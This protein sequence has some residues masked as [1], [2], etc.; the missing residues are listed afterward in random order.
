MG[1]I[2]PP[3]KRGRQMPPYSEAL[4]T[5]VRALVDRL[6]GSS[7][8]AK[9]RIESMTQL[10]EAIKLI[11]ELHGEEVKAPS[12]IAS[13][14]APP[15]ADDIDVAAEAPPPS[16]PPVDDSAIGADT[17]GNIVLDLLADI[18]D[19]LAQLVGADEEGAMPGEP[20]E[21]GE[22]PPVPDEGEEGEDGPVAAIPEPPEEEE[23]EE[24]EDEEYATPGKGPSNP[25][26]AD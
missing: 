19:F 18:R 11:E 24:E 5:N 13:E 17:Q 16:E 3:G 20:G 21:E 9:L 12:E 6:N 26:A 14:M 4:L 7:D 2:T 15:A 1:K 22:M 25:D 8:G 23:E 10:Q